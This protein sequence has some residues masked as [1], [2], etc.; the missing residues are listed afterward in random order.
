MPNYLKILLLLACAPTFAASQDALHLDRV[1]SQNISL[2]FENEQNKQAKKS[3]F[4]L[5]NYALMSNDAGERWAVVTLQNNAS[6][7]RFFDNEHLLALFADGQRNFPLA[8]QS[9]FKGKEI[10]SFTLSFGKNKFPI[11]ELKIKN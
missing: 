8:I 9:S 7:T 11:L 3:N 1:V 5:K 6:G 4:T 10:K 2:E